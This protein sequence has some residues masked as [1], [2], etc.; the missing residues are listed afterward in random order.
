MKDLKFSILIPTYKG[1]AVVGDTLKSI[2]SQSFSNYEI[3]ISED[4]SGDNI[5]EVVHSFNDSRIKFFQNEKNLG[6]P[7]NL[8]AARQRATG[9]IIY[10]MGQDD[11]LAED[12]LADTYNA[13]ESD[14]DIG[15]VTRPYFWFHD[16][17][18]KA[19][20]AKVQLNPKQ[21]EVV[22]MSDDYSRIITLFHTLDQL[23]GLAYRAKYFD[24]PFHPDIFPCHVYPFASIFK[25]H[26]A[27]FLKD[28]R[29]AVRIETSQARFLSSIYDKSP[30]QTWV[31]LFESV[32]SGDKYRDF[33]KHMIENF[34]A[35]NYIGTVQIKNFGKYKYVFREIALLI[36]YRWKNF[37]NPMFWVIS[38]GCVFIPATW[39]IRMVDWYKENIESKKLPDIEFKYKL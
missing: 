31:T 26:K 5:K 22:S 9:D 29:I 33:R 7:G 20:R 36:K 21:D 2:L 12:S 1:A 19:V 16:D 24:I 25:N 34:V 6:Y 35:K 4:A 38:F 28:H 13:F 17:I 10:L 18:H 39:L 8:E 23:S 27:T 11:I 14:E 3:I 15:V 32:F 30:V 37:F